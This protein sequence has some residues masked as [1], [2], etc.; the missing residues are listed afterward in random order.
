MEELMDIDISDSLSQIEDPFFKMSFE[1]EEELTKR[2]SKDPNMQLA[3]EDGEGIC[4][5]FLKGSCMKGNDCTYRHS[6][7][8]RSV[9]CKHWLRGLCKKGDLC[10]FLH[11]YD[12]S[13]MPECYFYSKFG[14]CS[15]PECMYLHINPEDKVKECP[16]YARGFCK[17]GPKCRHKHQPKVA[18]ENYLLGF[19]PDGPNCKY[20]HPKYELPKEDETKKARTPVICHN[21]GSVGHK[22]SACPSNNKLNKEAQANPRPLETVMCFKCTQLGHYANKCPNRRVPQPPGGYPLASAGYGNAPD[23]DMVD[24]DNSSRMQMV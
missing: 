3:G 23:R 10:E 2:D 9:V 11:Q 5:F 15:N 22:A 16:W 20:G 14:E 17:H 18:C 19:C 13:K 6:R 21:C 24:W 4:K 7:A 8:E 12:L 1:F